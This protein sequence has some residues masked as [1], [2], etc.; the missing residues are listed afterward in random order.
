MYV[1][2]RECNTFVDHTVASPFKLREVL[3][4]KGSGEVNEDVL[5]VENDLYIVCDGATSIN[6]VPERHVASGGQ[7]AAAIVAE[8]FSEN[9]RSLEKM[10]RRANRRIR[11]AM[12]KSSVDQDD[13]TALW[14]TSFAAVRFNGDYMEWAQSGDCLILLVYQDGESELLTDPPG[15]DIGTLKKWREIGPDVEGSIHEVLAMEIAA[16][17]AAMN[18]DYGVINGEA[19]ALDFVEYGVQ[20]ISSVED[21]LLFSDGLWLPTESPEEPLDISSIIALYKHMGLNGI[22]DHIRTFQQRDP[23]C[24]MYPR[25]KKF[26][27]I[28]AIALQR[29]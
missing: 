10:A 11:E 23:R 27:D 18:R 2:P 26:D 13:R 20:K 1:N 3:L 25:F 21:I 22:K 14:S 12:C 8:V 15:Q 6:E 9:D 29:R 17:R 24:W 28:S 19:K 16:V 7:Q 5:S 4:E